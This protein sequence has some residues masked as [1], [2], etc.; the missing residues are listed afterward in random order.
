MPA[1]PA[2]T[3]RV[4]QAHCTVTCP[5]GGPAHAIHA[6]VLRVAVL[7]WQRECPAVSPSGGLLCCNVCMAC[8]TVLAAAPAHPLVAHGIHE[9]VVLLLCFAR[10]LLGCVLAGAPVQCVVCASQIGNLSVQHMVGG[11]ACLQYV[12]N[13]PPGEGWLS[14]GLCSLYPALPRGL[15]NSNQ[16]L[17]APCVWALLSAVKQQ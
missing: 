16:D 9:W 15:H 2:A 10:R 12:H 17:Y 5:A 11:R 7:C 4:L 8:H 1:A 3:G 6:C 14:V 13:T